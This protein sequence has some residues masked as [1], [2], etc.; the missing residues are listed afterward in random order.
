MSEKIQTE[1]QRRMFTRKQV[2]AL[3]IPLMLEQILNSLMGMADTRV[4]RLLGT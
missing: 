2:F 4:A 1:D 3:I